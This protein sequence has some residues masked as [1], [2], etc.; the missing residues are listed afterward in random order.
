MS[1]KYLGFSLLLSIPLSSVAPAF[2]S[3]NILKLDGNLD[4]DAY[5]QLF[6]SASTYVVKDK[7]F[8]PEEPNQGLFTNWLYDPQAP[9]L[10]QVR[11]RYCLPYPGSANTESAALIGMDLYE[12]DQLLLSFDRPLG[13]VPTQRQIVR[14]A[15]YIPGALIPV[16]VPV[17]TSRGVFFRTILREGLPIYRPPVSCL[18]GSAG[19]DLTPVAP[20]LAKLP[21]KTLKIRLRFDN[22]ET[23]NWQLGG[24]TVRELKRLMT[25][26]DDLASR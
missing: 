10:F 4:S 3:D 24:G 22:G 26:R 25:L 15:S 20:Q 11:A 12:G 8:N 14:P 18:S 23:S 1:W 7:D 21:E 17:F 9:N 2:G 16:S 19:F 5:S 13:A 6:L